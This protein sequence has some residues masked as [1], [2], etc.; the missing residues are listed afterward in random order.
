MNL[1]KYTHPHVIPTGLYKTFNY[2]GAVL[3]FA[4]ADPPELEPVLLMV[5]LMQS[6]LVLSIRVR[7]SSMAP[8]VFIYCCSWCFE[9]S[10]ILLHRNIRIMI[11]QNTAAS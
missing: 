9:W 7:V 2:C 8:P 5:V 6:V 10:C 4:A 11:H 1:R 3:C